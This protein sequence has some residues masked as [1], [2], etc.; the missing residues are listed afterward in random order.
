MTLS[1]LL[2]A[3]LS[4]WFA[5]NPTP[6]SNCTGAVNPVIIDDG[7][8]I[9]V[10]GANSPLIFDDGGKSGAVNPVMIDDGGE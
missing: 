9:G 8:S 2:A 7:G 10:C 4:A 3:A 1:I 6:W 5:A